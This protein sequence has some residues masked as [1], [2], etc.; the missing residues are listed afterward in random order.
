MR[1]IQKGGLNLDDAS[2]FKGNLKQK[3]ISFQIFQEWALKKT[4]KTRINHTKSCKSIN[5]L[6][7][8]N[9]QTE[10]TELFEMDRF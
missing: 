7:L 2:F 5:H 10:A 3:R 1:G 8:L 9:Y 6:N 4:T